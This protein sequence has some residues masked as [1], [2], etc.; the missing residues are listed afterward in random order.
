LED[1][2]LLKDTHTFQTHYYFPQII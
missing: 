1:V 2:L